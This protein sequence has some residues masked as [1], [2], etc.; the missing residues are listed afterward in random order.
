MS[1]LSLHTEQYWLIVFVFV[2]GIDVHPILKRLESCN[3]RLPAVS[4][5]TSS[6]RVCTGISRPNAHPPPRVSATE[7]TGRIL[8]PLQA[9][10][11]FPAYPCHSPPRLAAKKKDKL[12]PTGEPQDAVLG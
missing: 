8:Y 4:C 11:L 2:L 12:T 1:K 10:S 9:S 6:H 3:N 7:D 5:E